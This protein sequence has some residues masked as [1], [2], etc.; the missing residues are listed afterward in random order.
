MEK[1]SAHFNVMSPMTTFLAPVSSTAKA[2]SA[3]CKSYNLTKRSNSEL[4]WMSVEEENF[5]SAQQRLADLA[6]KITRKTKPEL[7]T[8]LKEKQLYAEM[9]KAA[10]ELNPLLMVDLSAKPTINKIIGKNAFK[11]VRELKNPVMTMRGQSLKEECKTI[12][13]PI[14]T[15]K[16]SREKV[17]QAVAL[18]KKFGAKIRIVSIL[19]EVDEEIENKLIAYSNQ[20]WRFIKR[21]D[22]ECTIKT[23]RGSN[24]P[25]MVMDY[26][27]QVEADLIL[28]MNKTELS[29]VE[30]FM[31]SVA[32]QIIN[33]SDIPVIS[34]RPM[35]RKDTTYY[36]HSF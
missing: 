18:A 26:S 24:V 13:L 3:L 27:H 5:T 21:Q 7:E 2:I 17:G 35:A 19:T 11:A 4:V 9:H 16:E 8:E 31:G 6:T 12:V 15:S 36:V 29:L 28:I 33:E 23:L 10:D 22:I 25:K 1:N 14:D 20:V 32:E 30:T 34:Y